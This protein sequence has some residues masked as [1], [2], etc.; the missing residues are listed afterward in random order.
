MCDTHREVTPPAVQAGD[1][2][3]ALDLLLTPGALARSVPLHPVV[4]QLLR[5]AARLDVGG[6]AG[7]RGSLHAPLVDGEL[8]H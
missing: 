2:V 6:D 4:Q 1:A 3:V 5:G 7:E 8:A